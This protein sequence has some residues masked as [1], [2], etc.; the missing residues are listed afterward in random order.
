MTEDDTSASPRASHSSLN[1]STAVLLLD[2]ATIIGLG[3]VAPLGSGLLSVERANRRWRRRTSAPSLHASPRTRV[4]SLSYY[5][6]VA[7]H[8]N[9]SVSLKGTAR[10][11]NHTS[12]LLCLVFNVTASALA[13]GCH[14]E[15]ISR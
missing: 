1:P 7:P 10:A 14:V 9:C 11:L 15:P 8:D 13:R 2:I 4:Q 12:S 5:T 3:W 6:E